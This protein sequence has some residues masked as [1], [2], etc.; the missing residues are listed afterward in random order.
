[1]D[2]STRTFA[3]YLRLLGVE[4]AP[5]SRSLLNCLV[6][7]QVTRIPFENVS[8]LYAVRRLGRGRL[9]TLEE[10]LDG[11]ERYR[12]GG[13]CYVNNHS[14]Y[15]LLLHLG[16]EASFCGAQMT[17]HVDVHTVILVRL[18]GE[19]LLV[20]TGYGAP[21]HAPLS[22]TAAQPIAIDLGRDRYV[23]HPTDE[24]GRSRID[25]LR[26]GKLI[27]GYCVDPTPRDLDH[28]G[29]IIAE[30]Y[31]DDATFLNSLTAMRFRPGAAV[32]VINDQLVESDAAGSRL[33]PLPTPADRIEA[34]VTQFDMP[35]PI[36][37]EALA[38]L[39]ELKET[40]GGPVEPT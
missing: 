16:F 37:E 5:P 20:D 18:D 3:R 13:T 36:V 29:S 25:H 40:Q 39:G 2:S 19:E 31:A 12:F 28:F 8:K 14:L 38:G 22:R 9:P 15:R 17:N 34:I 27:H 24:R 10:F 4:P 32:A 6:D 21:F 1:M 35:R 30:S 7:R 11:I 33:T 23:L 26:H